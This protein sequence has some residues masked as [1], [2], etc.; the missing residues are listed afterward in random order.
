M[1]LVRGSLG[2]ITMVKRQ[3]EAGDHPASLVKGLVEQHP[4]DF[5]Q[6]YEVAV[7]TAPLDTITRLRTKVRDVRAKEWA[8]SGQGVLRKL[9][10]AS[11]FTREEIARFQE[12][13][14]EIVSKKR[15]ADMANQSRSTRR[16][17]VRTTSDSQSEQIGISKAEFLA[18]VNRLNPSLSETAEGLFDR[19]DEDRSGY[20]D[21]RELI[22]CMSLLSK[23]SFE[24][25]LRLCY[26]LF[27]YDHSGYLS[28]QELEA[29]LASVARHLQMN[30][31]PEE[32]QIALGPVKEK[33]RHCLDDDNMVSWSEF[34]GCITGD[35]VAFQIFSLHIE[36]DKLSRYSTGK[37]IRA[38]TGKEQLE[39][40]GGRAAAGPAM[41]PAEEQKRCH[42]V[43]S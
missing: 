4:Q 7:E 35:P 28:E 1:A 24:E 6:F 34:H 3:V 9:E 41:K 15:P 10:K 27:D 22:I 17:T 20:L 5:S 40:E 32:T 42:C 2:L 30:N 21:F 19:Y 33:L 23:G 12:A 25:K 11:H 18:L 37:L 8:E 16:V 13:F 26:D 38:V 36:T 14:D 31:T 29:L 43:I 39:Q